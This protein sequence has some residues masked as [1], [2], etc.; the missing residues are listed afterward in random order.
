M[1]QPEQYLMSVINL[2]RL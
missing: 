1:F 2:F